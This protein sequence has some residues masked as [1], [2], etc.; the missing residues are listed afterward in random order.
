[1]KRFVWEEMGSYGFD[2]WSKAAR[3][4]SRNYSRWGSP[5]QA[6][7]GLQPGLPVLHVYA[8]PDEASFLTAQQAFAA[9]HPWFHVQKLAAHSHFPMFEVPGDIVQ[10][11]ERFVAS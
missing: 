9:E 1:L 11:I 10:A 5:L 3:E 8:Q 2:M 7:A 4:I 6:L